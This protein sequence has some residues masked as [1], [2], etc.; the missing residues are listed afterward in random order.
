MGSR[1]TSEAPGGRGRNEVCVPRFPLESIEIS[2]YNSP[3]FRF[4]DGSSVE[5]VATYQKT[6]APTIIAATYGSGRVVLTGIHPE[7]M[8]GPPW[9]FRKR[10]THSACDK[11]GITSIASDSCRMCPDSPMAIA[12]T[13]TAE[14]S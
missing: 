9:E 6:G 8:P 1:P 5:V 12:A 13:T 2:Y 10:N 4:F 11:S 3:F 14:R 7:W